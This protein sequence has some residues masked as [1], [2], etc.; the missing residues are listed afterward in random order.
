METLHAYGELYPDE[1]EN[2]QRR[3]ILTKLH[4]ECGGAIVMGV[5]WLYKAVQLK[6]DGTLGCCKCLKQ[7]IADDETYEDYC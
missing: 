1:P 7:P 2:G 5:N 4:K 3:F 6:H